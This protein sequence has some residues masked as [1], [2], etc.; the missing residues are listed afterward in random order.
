MPVLPAIL[1]QIVA[2]L[3]LIL[4]LVL[5]PPNSV[6]GWLARLAGIGAAVWAIARIAQWAVTGWWMPLLSLIHI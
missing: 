6:A 5:W 2:P 3:A 4:W 1:L